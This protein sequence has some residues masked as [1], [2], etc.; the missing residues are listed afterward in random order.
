MSDIGI[1]FVVFITCCAPIIIL[2]LLY[3]HK[4]KLEHTQIMTAIEKGTPLSELK[5][6]KK[7]RPGPAWVSEYTSGI[8][9]V[10]IGVG[11][12]LVMF[13]MSTSRRSHMPA[14]PFAILYVVPIVFLA[15]GIA[16]IIRSKILKKNYPEL[17]NTQPE[18]ADNTDT[19]SDTDIQSG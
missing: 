9:C 7:P 14:F 11:F 8:T 4:K 2:A 16:A 15:N 19:T 13:V 10:V 12:L 3:Y 6:G 17:Q 18:I 1:I 5:P